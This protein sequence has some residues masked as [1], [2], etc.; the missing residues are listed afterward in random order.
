MAQFSTLSTGTTT[1]P[2]V[3]C[4]GKKGPAFNRAVTV[5]APFGSES[6]QVGTRRLLCAGKSG[7]AF[8]GRAAST[9]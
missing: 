8:D 1:G 3:V 4:V 6:R 9:R 5:L 7:P 2:R